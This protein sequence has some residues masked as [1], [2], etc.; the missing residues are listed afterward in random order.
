VPFY[1]LEFTPS[2]RYERYSDFGRTTRPKLG[3]D[4]KPV[5]GLMLRASFNEGFSAPNLPTL[6]APTQFSID[7]APGVTDPYRNPVTNEGAYVQRMIFNGNRGLRPVT[8]I[9]KSAG[10]VLDVP[11]V[12]GL[13]MTVDYWQ[14]DQ[15]NLIGSRTTTQILNSDA[16][17]LNAYTQSQLAAGKTV[18]QLDAGS[19]AANYQGDPAVVR[20]PV[21]AADQA[22]FA[23][24]NATHASA[25][26]APVGTIVSRSATYANLAKSYAS[27]VDLSL[28]YALPERAFGRVNFSAE[29]TYSRRLY[30]I[31][32]PSGSAPLFLERMNVDGAT[33]WRGNATIAWHRGN[34]CAH[35]SGYYIGAFADSGATTTAAN[36]A[37][38]GAPNYLSRQFDSGGYL[39]RYVVHAVTSFNASI[40][41][42]F[43]AERAPFLAR[44]SV[45]LG[46]VN[47]TD[48]QPP[49]TSGA[50]GYSAAVHGALYAGRTFT[51]ECTRSF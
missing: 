30:Q 47:L 35:A 37:N 46:V 25:P 19:G 10:L 15:T 20:N 45:R 40:G 44:T 8:S 39:Y 36:Y 2:L 21:T 43:S 1:A 31:S 23:A 33:R 27:G 3:L 48:R 13:A 5:R 9:G 7:I 22:A 4:W 49:L 26:L 29:W 16:A 50:A 12:K 41:Y 38:L 18:A 42:R 32:R 34:W 28:S 51:G 14:I 17:L 6:Y 24:Y 11:K